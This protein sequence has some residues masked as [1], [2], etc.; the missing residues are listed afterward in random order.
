MY[1][2]AQFLF[3][4]SLLIALKI[5]KE[6]YKEKYHQSYETRHKM[7]VQVVNATISVLKSKRG[8][9]ILKKL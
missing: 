3:F 4:L 7:C 6:T 2:T 9:E 1:T 5:H 8:S